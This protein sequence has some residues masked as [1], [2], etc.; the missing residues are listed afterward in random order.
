MR[1]VRIPEKLYS[2][3]ESL[4]QMKQFEDWLRINWIIECWLS[5]PE[6]WLLPKHITINRVTASVSRGTPIV[7]TWGEKKKTSVLVE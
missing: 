3:P 7:Y 4:S 5:L 1:L 6:T 2:N